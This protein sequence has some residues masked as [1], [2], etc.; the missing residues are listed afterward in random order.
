[1]YSAQAWV[2]QQINVVPV[3]KEGIFGTG[4]RVRIN[5]SGVLKSHP[6]F[7]GKFDVDASCSTYLPEEP[8]DL[9]ENSHGTF[10]TSVLAANSNNG[11]CAAGIAPGVTLSACNIFD[12]DNSDASVL[13]EKLDSFDIS[14]NSWGPTICTPLRKRRLEV[15]ETCPFVYKDPIFG[16][17][18]DVCD[19]PMSTDN[20]SS[21][22]CEYEIRDHCRFNYEHEPTACLDFW[23]LFI[24]GCAYATLSQSEQDAFAKGVTEGRNGK[25]I[26]YVF[27]AGNEHD[28]GSNVNFDGYMNTR[29]TIAVGATSKGDAL[30]AYYSTSGAAMFISAPGG[31]KNDIHVNHISAAMDGGCGD[32]GEGTSYSCPVVA[33]VIA[34]M[35]EARPDLGWRDVQGI[36]AK[37]A[38]PVVYDPDN[39]W[40]ANAAGFFH[41]YYYG[42]GIIDAHAAVTMAKEWKLWGKER[43]I[44]GESGLLNMP[45]IDD[46]SQSTKSTVSIEDSSLSSF[47]AESVVAYV[48]LRHLS[49]GD[50]AIT[51]TS[52][53]GT[54]S[55]LIPGNRPENYQSGDDESWKMMSLRTWGEDVLGEWKL[56]IRDDNPGYVDGVTGGDTVDELIQWTL[57]VYGH[58]PEEEVEPPFVLVDGVCHLCPDGS[59]VQFPYSDRIVPNFS[60]GQ[61]KDPPCSLLEAYIRQSIATTDCE[62]IQ[63]QAGFCGCPGIE[64][65]NACSLCDNGSS[66]GAPDRLTAEGDTCELLDEYISFMKDEDCQSDGGKFLLAHAALCEC[67]GAEPKCTLCSQGLPPPD[68]AQ[69]V[70]DG[71]CG[72][73][74]DLILTFSEEQCVEFDRAMITNG[75]RCGCREED[76]PQCSVSQNAEYCTH[77]LLDNAT[78]ECECH[79]FCDGEFIG[80]SDISGE[81]VQECEGFLVSGCNRALP[82]Y[83]CP[84]KSEVTLRDRIIPFFNLDE[85]TPDPTCSQ[86]E[87]FVKET[88]RA[89]LFCEN[90]EAQA[91]FC[92]CAGVEEPLN[93]CSLCDGGAA[94][95]LPNKITPDGDTCEEINTYVSFMTEASCK[96]TRGESILAYAALC[97]CPGAVPSCSVCSEGR[98]VPVPEWEV[99]D[100]QCGVINDFIISFSPDQCEDTDR[101]IKV[102]GIRCGCRDRSEMP[103]CSIAQ[104]IEYCTQSLLETATKECECYNFCD[105]VFIGCSDFPGE[106]INNCN[107]VVVSGCNEAGVVKE[108]RRSAATSPKIIL[109]TGCNMLISLVLLFL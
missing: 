95:G 21:L 58:V 72:A 50:L 92:G 4:V 26:I 10:V 20:F 6:E 11:E 41:S 9:E 43:M 74:E 24:E 54:E 63:K 12:P 53:H 30:H 108:Q 106:F 71:T 87:A 70:Q 66:P 57:V 27:A 102:N 35:L 101:L 13:V 75:I 51:L 83:I 55:I 61:Y 31:D 32:A 85:N 86:L 90:F 84:D 46:S 82:C 99:Q 89:S 65:K 18:C 68:R 73:I 15:L 93:A 100:G 7:A 47:V 105:G 37:T 14:Q 5:D 44:M 3:W 80:C 96:S 69:E 67:P 78:E 8:Y 94:P 16:S 23:D 64:P 29:F 2:Y 88:P 79:N 25:G 40:V 60:L 107:G 45:L 49:R 59:D 91:G 104:N 52:P 62:L 34:L 39:D 97:G 48:Y 17:P 42:F 98:E 22:E 28:L 56:A 77:D 38:Y 33:G 1:M 76:F 109:L 19:F 81:N 36:V 103:K